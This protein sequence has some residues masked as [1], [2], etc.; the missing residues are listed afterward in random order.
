MKTLSQLKVAYYG[1]DFTGATD[2]LAT[3]AAAGLRSMLFLRVPDARQLEQ[4]GELDCL[5]IAGAARSMT[6]TEMHSELAPVAAFFARLPAPLLHY[7][8][9]STFD[10]SPEI[11]NIGTAIEAFRGAAANPLVAIV[12]GQPNLQRFCVFGNLFASAGTGGTVHRIDRHPTMSRHPVT[13]MREGDLRLHLAQQGVDVL[14]GINYVDYDDE[15]QALDERL[16]ACLGDQAGAVLFDVARSADLATI[17]R[18]LWESAQRKR[19]LAVGPSSVLQALAAHWNRAQIA[20]ANAG[21]TR[22]HAI[23]RATSAGDGPV[24]VVAGSLSPI[25]ATQVAASTSYERMQL[26]ARRLAA[27]EHEY[28]LAVAAQAAGMLRSGS[29]V[30][31]VTADALPTG[32]PDTNHGA[33]VPS[34][35]V[36]MATARFVAEVLAQAPVRRLGIAGGD[37]ASQAVL[38]LGAWGLSH[39]AKLAEGVA[40]CRLHADAP[41]L[42]GL[43]VM[44]KGGQMGPVEIFEHLLHGVP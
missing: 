21:Q 7:K 5:G 35:A 26:D 3:A 17:G 24:L 8:I 25:T 44:L 1:D 9:C 12:G 16:A 43:E 22:K 42:N 31:A 6:R 37:S 14:G 34:R 28:I 19:L 30:L 13:P 40:L 23:A 11:G 15:T 33:R 32:T 10:S 38:G 39:S 4:A 36:A 27:G 41:L 29:S 2:T 18:V 20:D